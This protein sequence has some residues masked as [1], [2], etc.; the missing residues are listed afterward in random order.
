ML[1]RVARS[2]AVVAIAASLVVAVPVSAQAWAVPTPTVAGEMV[3]GAVRAAAPRIATAAEFAGRVTPWGTLLT[4]GQIMYMTRDSWMPWVSNEFG[5]GGATQVNTGGAPCFAATPVGP[6]ANPGTMTVT[7]TGGSACGGGDLASPSAGAVQCKNLVTGAYSGGGYAAGSIWVSNGQ[8]R[9]GQF[10]ASCSAGTT[11]T[12]WTV[13]VSDNG[14]HPVVLAW[15][16]PFSPQTDATYSVNVDCLLADGTIA[17]ITETT[18]SPQGGGLAVPSCAAAYPGSHGVK[19]L[20]NGAPT[21][22]PLI[23]QYEANWDH[24]SVLYPNCVGAG[25]ACS[26]VLRYN[27]VPCVAG[28]TECIGWALKQDTQPDK[29]ECWYGPYQLTLADCG[30]LERAYEPNGTT[31]TKLN[32]DGD[33]RTYDVTDPNGNPIPG[34][35]PGGTPA[36]APAPSPPPAGAPGGAPVPIDPTAPL[37]GPTTPPT[38]AGN[39]WS[40]SGASWNPLDWVLRPVQCALSWAF[41]PSSAQISGPIADFKTTWNS[42]PPGSLIV[43][44][45]TVFGAIGTGWDG[46]CSGSASA[47]FSQP[48][49]GHP[50]QLPCTPTGGGSGTV[51]Y[52]AMQIALIVATLIY[53]WHMVA[54]GISA[55]ATGSG[56]D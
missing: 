26:Y 19:M 50:L 31:L 40:S 35:V 12:S 29:Y 15:G 32:T 6:G 37:P 24:S 33:P 14:A 23:K 16:A 55:Q 2:G 41:V 53:V 27:G 1:G 51:P 21:G 20:V 11:M 13:T 4:V 48:A 44:A 54:A 45:S 5:V 7:L 22:A 25:V 34:L 42:K 18:V 38:T 49:L 56:G 17:T 10:P 52:T 3:I 47:S 43:G 8:V 28:Q 46:G 36:P 30:L 39:C 9:T